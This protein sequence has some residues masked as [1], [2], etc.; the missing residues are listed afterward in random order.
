MHLSKP[1]M[2]FLSIAGVYYIAIGIVALINSYLIGVI[3]QV[4][5]ICYSGMIL[6]GIGLA[7]KDATLILAE[8][9]VLAVTLIVW[10][11]DFVYHLVTHT[12]L[13]GLTQYV[14]TQTAFLPRFISLQ[15][16]IML[17]IMVIALFIIKVPRKNNAW[18]ISS[19]QVLLLYLLTYLITVPSLNTNCVFKSCL[20]ILDLSAYYPWMWFIAMGVMIALTQVV[21]MS[22]RPFMPSSEPQKHSK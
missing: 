21:I 17:P 12:P 6:L 16:L 7:R 9:N 4:F 1:K 2:L 13:W 8:C 11:I 3:D 5:W 19:I 10:S 22:S 15:H 20:V 18:V 14:F